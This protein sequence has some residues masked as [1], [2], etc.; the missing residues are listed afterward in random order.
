MTSRLAGIPK[1]AGKF[2]PAAF[3]MREPRGSHDSASIDGA[4]P[5]LGTGKVFKGGLRE[6]RAG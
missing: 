6:S 5:A 4:K 2:I 1:W 3:S